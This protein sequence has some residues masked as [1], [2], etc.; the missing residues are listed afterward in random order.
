MTAVPTRFVVLHLDCVL[1]VPLDCATRHWCACA[2]RHCGLLARIVGNIWQKIALFIWQ[3]VDGQKLT[4]VP[5]FC[6]DNPIS[7]M[8]SDCATAFNNSLPLCVK[9]SWPKSWPN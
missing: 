6:T 9:G 1:T 7:S 2:A 3:K 4:S 5:E 8:T